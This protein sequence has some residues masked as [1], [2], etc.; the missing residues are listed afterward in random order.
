MRLVEFDFTPTYKKGADN[1]STDALSRSMNA[2]D[3]SQ[4]EEDEF[5]DKLKAEQ[6]L[7]QKFT[8]IITGLS[9]SREKDRPK[10]FTIENSILYRTAKTGE[11][12]LALPF[13]RIEEALVAC[14]EGFAGGHLGQDNTCDQVK[15]RIW[16]PNAY[17]RTRN[18]VESCSV[19][20]ARNKAAP[21][22]AELRPIASAHQPFEMLGVD[23]LGPLPE[24]EDP[25]KYILVLTDYLTKW[26][27]AFEIEEQ[28]ARKVA[29]LLIGRVVA[30]HS[31]PRVLL[32]DQGASFLS[33]VV[34]KASEILRINK[35]NTAA[36]NP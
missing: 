10:G 3:S 22:K 27:E 1:I 4:A 15:E 16:W 25:K 21:Y 8:K 12:R 18:W 14:H 24:T 32:S 23:I 20:A 33:S 19:N 28:S 36:Y 2:I 7:D 31:A 30:R 6:L 26:V 13:N 9:S 29:E 35:T 17:F 34:K 11:R 5:K